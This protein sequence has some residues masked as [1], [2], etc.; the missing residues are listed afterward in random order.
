MIKNLPTDLLRAYVTVVQEKS[1]SAAGKKLGRSQPAISLQINRLEDLAGVPLMVRKSR[2]FSLT[3]EG[4]VL[5]EYA[6]RIL[7]LNDEA[8]LRLQ[9]PDVSGKVRLGIPHEFASSYL[10]DF[11]SGFAKTYPGVELEVI[12]ELS[13]TLLGRQERGELD[14]VVAIHRDPAMVTSPQ[15]WREHLVWVTGDNTDSNKGEPIPLVVAPHGCV[16]RYRMLRAL[17]AKSIPWRIVYT[18][19]SYGGICAAVT[20]GLGVTVLA[21]NTVP[22]DLE[23]HVST[24]RL[25]ALEE[26]SVDLHYERQQTDPAVARL[27]EYITRV[28]RQA[29]RSA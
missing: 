7:R 4:E 24:S 21:G 8:V 16:Y 9:K 3:E 10:S 6:R 22:A 12:S 17:D 28:S 25:P 11:L 27:V 5:L 13:Q 19:P 20:A 15:G 23:S 1:F 18:G 2:S 29:I 14:L 26:A